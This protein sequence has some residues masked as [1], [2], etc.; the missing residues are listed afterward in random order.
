MCFAALVFAGDQTI[1]RQSTTYPQVMMSETDWNVGT[2]HITHGFC[3]LL[4]P[5]ERF[6]DVWEHAKDQWWWHHK[7]RG[8][9]STRLHICRVCWWLDDMV[10]A[11]EELPFIQRGFFRILL[12][13]S[14]NLSGS[15]PLD[16]LPESAKQWACFEVGGR[17]EENRGTTSMSSLLALPKGFCVKA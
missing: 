8:P 7:S 14:L 16:N 5:F 13:R 4:I 17:K 2:H 15:S 9:S 3:K 10:L 12:D 6:L 11:F 1:A